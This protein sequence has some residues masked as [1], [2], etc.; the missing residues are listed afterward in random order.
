MLDLKNL[1]DGLLTL[2]EA[3]DY[4]R[5][6]PRAV[7]DLCNRRGL[8]HIRLDRYNWRFRVADLEAFLNRFAFKAKGVR[9]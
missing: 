6:K 7:R 1:G 3:A 9:A 4:L 2:E 8:S 5:L